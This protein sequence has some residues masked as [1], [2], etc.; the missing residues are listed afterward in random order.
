MRGERALLSTAPTRIDLAGGTL[1]IWPLSVLV[2]G[3][4]TVNLAVGLKAEV[5]IEALPAKG[6]PG[7]RMEIISLDRSARAVRKLP[8]NPSKVQGPLALLIR[9]AASFAPQRSF[10]MV[11]RA[12]APAGAGLGGSSSLGIAAAGALNRFTGAGMSRKRL[13]RRV[14]NLETVELRVPTGNQDH[15]AAVHGGLAAYRHTPDGT[16]RTAIPVP[17]GLGERLVLAYT[18][19]PRNSGASN[20]DMF[21]RYIDGEGT[22]VSRM[23]AIARLA[24]EMTDA[25]ASGDLDQIGRLVGEEGKLRNR[26]APSVATPSIKAAGRAA[27][28]AGAL[29]IKVCGAGGGGCMVALASAGRRDAVAAALVRAGCRIL[30]AGLGVRGLYVRDLPATRQ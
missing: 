22:T 16:E 18:G 25:L 29:G 17:N 19:L 9:L 24:G 23:E 3:A 6:K 13:L 5:R 15:L 21:R 7:S 11:C 27:A 10:R 20:W 1:D 4:I 26:L 2:P 30:E 28:R 8:V 14:L 12:E